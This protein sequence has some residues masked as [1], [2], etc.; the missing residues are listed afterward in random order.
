MDSEHY[1]S[2][3]VFGGRDESHIAGNFT[4]ADTY[5]RTHLMGRAMP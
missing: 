1:K 2:E 5:D 3:V 4:W